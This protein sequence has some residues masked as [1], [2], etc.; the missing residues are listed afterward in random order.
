MTHPQIWRDCL[1]QL[2]TTIPVEELTSWLMPLHSVQVDRTLKLLAPNRYV[3]EHIKNNLQ[4]EIEQAVFGL[5]AN[6]NRVLFEVGSY[7]TGATGA[8]GTNGANGT[9]GAAGTNGVAPTPRAAKS[10]YLNGSLNRDYTFTNHVKGVSNQLARAAAQQVGKN[11][12]KSYNPLFIYGGVGLGKTHLMQAAGNTA[13]QQNPGAKVAYVR[14]ERFVNDMVEALKKGQMDKFKRHYRS[15]DMLLIDDI[16]FLARKTMSQEEFFNT[17]N[18]LLE[19]Q[20]Q[21]VITSDRMPKAIAHVEERLT[22]RFG[23]GLTVTVE[24]PELETRV[25]ILEKKAQDQGLVLSREVAFFVANLIYSNVREL[26]GALCRIVASSRLTGRV[27]DI[28]LARE[29]LRDL[30]AFQEK[31]ISID[32]IQQTIAGYYKIRVSDLLSKDRSRRVTRPRQLAMFFAK[33]YTNLSLPQIGD[34]FGGKDHTTVLHACKKITEL[35]Q[36]D[37]NMKKDHDNLQHLLMG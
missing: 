14:S 22:S 7:T 29:E 5:D 30:L 24:P 13:L 3:L 21:I 15:L 35:L 16:Q 10:H 20:K 25:A 2:R 19:G 4:P 32:N 8:T 31:R 36:S 28:D 18:A 33:A 23:S 26:E 17:F 27:V 11:T 12:G 34:Y 1:D 9:N 6:I 37:P